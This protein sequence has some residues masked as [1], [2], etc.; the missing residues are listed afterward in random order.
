MSQQQTLAQLGFD[1]DRFRKLA[2]RAGV[3]GE[4]IERTL[5]Y[6]VK[7]PPMNPRMAWAGLS[8][9]QSGGLT[10]RL[11]QQASDFT[12]FCFRMCRDTIC[13]SEYYAG[14]WEILGPKR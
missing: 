11:Y 8:A 4:K 10:S 9:T 6:M 7:D 5:T 3:D 1:T 12:E 14:F 2:I 13:P